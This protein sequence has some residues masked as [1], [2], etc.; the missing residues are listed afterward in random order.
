M[1]PKEAKIIAPGE[2]PGG[3]Q[4]PIT[5]LRRSDRYPYRVFR[6]FCHSFGVVLYFSPDP[7]LTPGAIIRGPFRAVVVWLDKHGA[8]HQRM[9]ASH[10][11]VLK[12]Q[13]KSIIAAMYLY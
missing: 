7:G 10:Y 2:N 4:H 9:S 5:E 12:E 11:R 8:C 13:Q 6:Y 3:C 1:P